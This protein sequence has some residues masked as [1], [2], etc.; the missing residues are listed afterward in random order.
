M[1]FK[2]QHTALERSSLYFKLIVHITAFGRAETSERRT[3][4]IISHLSPAKPFSKLVDEKSRWVARL[5][6]THF[7]T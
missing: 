6:L 2:L 7:L 4:Y 1:S 5:R 3:K